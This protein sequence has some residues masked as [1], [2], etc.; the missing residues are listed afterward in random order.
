MFGL[1]L[2]QPTGQAALSA[3]GRVRVQQAAIGLAVKQLAGLPI[4]GLG[5]LERP[6]SQFF[7]T[8]A[9]ARL[10]R[11]LPGPVAGPTLEILTDAFLGRKR[12]CHSLFL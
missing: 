11:A 12:V 2:V 9:Q 1:E 3:G 8:A 4:G 10:E 7:P 5:G 6:P